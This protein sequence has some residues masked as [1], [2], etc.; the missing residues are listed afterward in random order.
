M[1]ITQRSA[2]LNKPRNF[3]EPPRNSNNN[4]RDYSVFSNSNSFKTRFAQVYLKLYKLQSGK[5]KFMLKLYKQYT[6][7][8]TYIEWPSSEEKAVGEKSRM[9]SGDK[10]DHQIFCETSSAYLSTFLYS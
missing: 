2:W 4:Q 5:L 1:I 8:Y 10:V 7:I 6:F 3:L 9:E